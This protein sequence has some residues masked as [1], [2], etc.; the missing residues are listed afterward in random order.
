[1]VR[2]GNTLLVCG[3]KPTPLVTS[4]FALRLVMSSPCNVTLPLRTRTSPNS[5]LSRVDLPAP[6]GPMIPTISP[7][8]QYRSQSLRMLTSGT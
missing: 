6:L 8:V 2:L 3:T 1:M 7:S 5:A 4:S